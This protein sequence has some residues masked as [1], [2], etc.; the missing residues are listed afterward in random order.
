VA[1]SSFGPGCA[2]CDFRNTS[3]GIGQAVFRM[4]SEAFITPGCGS[5]FRIPTPRHHTVAV[6]EASQVARD[7]LH[8]GMV[9][10]FPLDDVGQGYDIALNNPERTL[11][12]HAAIALRPAAEN[13]VLVHAGLRPRWEGGDTQNLEGE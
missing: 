2:I 4:T 3:L 12:R 13:A 10:L 8:R 11:G 9:G 6:I 7:E 5:G 1:D